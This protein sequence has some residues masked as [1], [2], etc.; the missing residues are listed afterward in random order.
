MSNPSISS[1]FDE[2]YDST[3]KSVLAFITAKCRN[4]ADIND[5]F[6]DTYMELYQ[7]LIKRGDNYVKNE[8]AFLIRLAKQKL[9][10]YYSLLERMKIVVSVNAANED[11]EEFDL[12]DFEIDSF[13][14]ED[15]AVDQILLDDARKIIQS[16]PD[17]V[18]K[19]FYLFYD[20]GLTIPEIAESLSMSESNVKNKLYRTLKELQNLLN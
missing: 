20:V 7:V 10:R 11:G 16:K 17:E 4:T 1:R 6:Q 12:S 18:K 15:Y 14:M 19:V 5:I 3:S 2:I 9:A 13:L 8:K